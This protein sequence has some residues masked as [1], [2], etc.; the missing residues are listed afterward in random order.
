MLLLE[1][2]DEGLLFAEQELVLCPPEK[3]KLGDEV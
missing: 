2:L 1:L 3:H